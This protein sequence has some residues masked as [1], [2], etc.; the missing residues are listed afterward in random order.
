MV[1]NLF[2][3][4]PYSA[5]K[6]L[7]GQRQAPKR[8]QRAWRNSTVIFQPLLV[9]FHPFAVV[10]RGPCHQNMGLACQEQLGVHVYRYEDLFSTI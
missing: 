5:E 1:Y 7:P 10:L 6:M 3:Y 8:I 2:L 4:L 9:K